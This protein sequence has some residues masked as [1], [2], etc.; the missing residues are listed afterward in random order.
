MKSGCGLLDCVLA[1]QKMSL[2]IQREH[3]LQLEL[4]RARKL[5]ERVTQDHLV[6][7]QQLL[8]DDSSLVLTEEGFL[9]WGRILRWG[10]FMSR[11]RHQPDWTAPVPTGHA[12]MPFYTN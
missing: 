10:G 1:K 5:I 11:G 7:S 2:E 6:A 9:I 12:D 8:K 4:E 3:R